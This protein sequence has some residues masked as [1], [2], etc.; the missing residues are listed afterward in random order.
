MSI[1]I[2]DL[3]VLLPRADEIAR[4]LPSAHQQDTH[5]QALAAAMQAEVERQRRRVARARA[6]DEARG[7][8]GRWTARAQDQEAPAE[9]PDGLG[10]RLDVRA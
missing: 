10:R 9:R 5:Q 3:Q 6:G 2:S 1:Q 7:A 8:D 4:T